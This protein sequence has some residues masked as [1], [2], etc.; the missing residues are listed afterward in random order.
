MQLPLWMDGYSSIIFKCLFVANYLLKCE[1]IN[2]S[3]DTKLESLS[4]FTLMS[5]KSY[6][7]YFDDGYNQNIFRKIVNI[8]YS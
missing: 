4:K 1:K 3:H 7:V 6:T 8:F 2:S 5:H